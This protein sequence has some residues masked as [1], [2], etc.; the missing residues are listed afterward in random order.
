MKP[1]SGIKYALC[2]HSFKY[3][4]IEAPFLTVFPPNRIFSGLFCL[5]TYTCYIYIMRF[6]CQQ[7]HIQQL[8]STT[9]EEEILRLL[10]VVFVLFFWQFTERERCIFWDFL[11]LKVL[12]NCLLPNAAPSFFLVLSVHNCWKNFTTISIQLVIAVVALRSLCATIKVQH[13]HMLKD[14][15]AAKVI[16]KDY[17]HHHSF[18][19]E[20][21]SLLKK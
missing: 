20:Y 17:D 18:F 16:K 10:S 5:E 12:S 11:S 21:C 9:T 6:Q 15:T 19:Y 8:R 4:E 2:S 7:Q 3:S 14:K 13:A 1:L